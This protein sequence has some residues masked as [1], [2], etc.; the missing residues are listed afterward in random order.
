MKPIILTFAHYYLP[1]YQ[2][3]GPI[4]TL[5]NM[6]ER[7]SDSF[8]FRIVALDRDLGDVSPYPD[9]LPDTWM[10]RGEA[11]VRHVRPQ[12]FGL[13]RVA[14]IVRSTPHDAIYLNSFFDPRFTQSVL[15]NHRLG[16]L[17]GRPIVIAARGEFSAGAL[18]IKRLKKIIFIGLAKLFK[19]YDGLTWQASGTGEVLDIQRVLSVGRHRTGWARVS[20]EVLAVPDLSF[21][22]GIDHASS[23][24]AETP[25]RSA[26]PLRVCFLS[27]IS[28][29][30]NLDVALRVLAHVRVPVR[31]AI[32]GPIEDAAYW[33]VCKT[34]IAKLPSN[35]EVVHEGAIEP[36]HIESTLA[37]QDLF[38]FPTRGESFGHVIH[39]ALRAGLP[40][41][42]SD[43]TPWRHLEERGVGWDLP[44][45]DLSAFSRRIEEVA[46]WSDTAC[47]MCSARARTL[48]AEVA[49]DPVTLE[50]NRRLFLDVISA[51]KRTG[52]APAR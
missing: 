19:I 18:R 6:V 20:G 50:A 43:Q 11:L 29:M 12:G 31:F 10:P 42:I 14:E 28:P 41:L 24:K 3:G 33:T 36:A 23:G 45:G 38:L 48:A 4:R 40:V 27:R 47:R 34:L 32:Y 22:S 21:S 44:L 46:A 26:A 52:R 30:K 7:L 35:V 49:Q 15:V 51:A 9:V 8:E 5:A 2:A 13:R 1:G 37:R 17:C 25:R 16:R 39:E